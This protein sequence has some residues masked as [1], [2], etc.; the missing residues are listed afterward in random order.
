MGAIWQSNEYY[1]NIKR[2]GTTLAKV[3]AAKGNANHSPI[4]LA[5]AYTLPV[6]ISRGF[7]TWANCERKSVDDKTESNESSDLIKQIEGDINGILSKYNDDNDGIKTIEDLE[8]L[9]T[10]KDYLSSQVSNNSNRIDFL[11]DSNKTFQGQIDSL[12]EILKSFNFD[13]PTLE[14]YE[15]QKEEISNKINNLKLV[16]DKNKKEIEKLKEENTKYNKELDKLSN[17]DQDIEDF[18]TYMG[19]LKKANGQEVIESLKNDKTSEIN[20]LMKEM[21]TANPKKRKSLKQELTILLTE[22]LNT[23]GP[24]NPTLVKYANHLGI[25]Q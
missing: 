13:L 22:Y 12:E 15:Q 2:S 1:T 9:K 24:K 6:I 7:T 4:G 3:N 25:N 17:I 11:E 8:I 5:L 10:K 14:K 18:K 21:K 19:Q 16:L 23:D 20:K